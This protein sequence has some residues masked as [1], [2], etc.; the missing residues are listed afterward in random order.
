MLK[1][2]WLEN[3]AK[4]MKK[5]PSELCRPPKRALKVERMGGIEPRCFR[6]RTRL[7]SLFLAYSRLIIRSPKELLR[8]RCI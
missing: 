5:P 4:G 6:L 3:C 8:F 1:T 7:I 2:S